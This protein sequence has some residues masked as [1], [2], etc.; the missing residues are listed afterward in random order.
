MSNALTVG[1]T[2]QPIDAATVEPVSWLEIDS[3]YLD[4]LD[5]GCTCGTDELNCPHCNRWEKARRMLK[6]ALTQNAAATQTREA[7]ANNASQ[8]DSRLS[9]S[10]SDVAAAPDMV[11][12]KYHELLY[13][14]GNKWPGETRHET[15]LRYIRQAEQ[16][17]SGPSQA[18]AERGKP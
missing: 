12:E 18:A 6:S 8:E 7:S 1:K 9:V 4:A 16:S 17:S 15:A 11:Q 10:R 13:A 2:R 14:V 3:A 5:F